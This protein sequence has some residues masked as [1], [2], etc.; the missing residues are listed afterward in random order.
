[1]F[2]ELIKYKQK[3]HFFF[4]LQDSLKE[5]CNAPTDKSGVYIVYALKNG[6]T[7]LIYIGRLGKIEKDGSMFIRKAGLGGIKD[8]IV[9]GHQFGK[10][11]RRISWPIQMT[12]EKIEALDIYWFATHNEKY[13]DCPRVLENKLLQN[14]L[15]MYGRL[16]RWNNEL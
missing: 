8:R 6:K 16:P 5:V 15:D 7:E 3:D 2:D 9:N 13:N 12:K 11:P 1:M 10:I 4:Q 14:H